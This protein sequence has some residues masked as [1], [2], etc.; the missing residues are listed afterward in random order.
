MRFVKI[1]NIEIHKTE[2][3]S[4]VIVSCLRFYSSKF[5]DKKDEKVSQE[6]LLKANQENATI[7]ANKRF[8][9]KM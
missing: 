6:D 1:V 4:L 3:V 2:R 8:V 9:A 7:S 5:L